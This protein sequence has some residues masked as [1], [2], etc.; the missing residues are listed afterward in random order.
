MLHENTPNTF[1]TNA[2]HEIP[3]IEAPPLFETAANI[4]FSL[5]R[6]S[7]I[8]SP[9]FLEGILGNPRDNDIMSTSQS[10]MEYLMA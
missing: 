6:A 9:S 10:V 3:W 1:V 4:N 5:S 7:F 8:E 2:G